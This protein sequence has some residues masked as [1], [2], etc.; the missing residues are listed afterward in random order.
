MVSILFSLKEYLKEH[1][2]R[3]NDLLRE[4]QDEQGVSGWIKRAAYWISLKAVNRCFTVVV[5]LLL[6][7]FPERRKRV[8][9]IGPELDR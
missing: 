7:W 6:W 2:Y 3:I 5:W 4:M 9:V 8:T 1:L